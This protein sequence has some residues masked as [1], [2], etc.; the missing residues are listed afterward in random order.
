MTNHR[1]Y[2]TRAIPQNGIDL[3]RDRGYEVVI[4]EDIKPLKPGALYKILKKA[5]KEGKGYDAVLT[6]LTDK[7]NA[8]IVTYAPKLKVVSNY[9]I[10]Y[11]NLDVKG[12]SD[13]QVVVT[14]APGEYCATVAE[15]V[16][17]LIL[18]LV[19]NITRGD[20]FVR[21]G[22][23]KGWDPMLFV[24]QDISGKT[25][26]LIG[27]GRIGEKVA[28]FLKSAFNMN[29]V[30]F[31][32]RQNEMLEKNY[33]AQKAQSLDELLEKADV[34]SIHVP[35]LPS[36]RH[37][38]DE[39]FIKKMKKTAYLINSSRGPVVDEKVLIKALRRGWIQGAGLDVFE[40]EPKISRGLR[41]LSNVVMTPHIAS[42][43][44][45]ARNEMSRIA[46][47]NI[48]DVFEGRT[49]KGLVRPQ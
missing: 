36:T 26:G 29:I 19:R 42:A 31:D 35:L 25:L 43:S 12:L 10:G 4:G 49:P 37:M 40:F 23:Y 7:V 14:N 27:A 2:V 15:H 47:E 41:R 9:A 16:V 22:L 45:E 39:S 30:Y 38:V 32:T 24:G 17:G 46:C 44:D 11:D 28:Q 8:D 48:I 20:R 3:L 34:V 18:S 33:S 21:A 1:V 5:E 6:L 13:K